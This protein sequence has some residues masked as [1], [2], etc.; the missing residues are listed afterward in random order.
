MSVG[1]PRW[2]NLLVLAVLR[3]PAHGLLDTRICELTY[4]LPRSGKVVTLPVQYVMNRGRILV[5]VAQADSKRWWRAFRRPTPVS[6]RLRG[7]VR[8]G[9]GR[10]LVPSSAGHQEALL[11]YRIARGTAVP[12]GTPIVVLDAFGTFGPAAEGQRH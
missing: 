12:T 3:S 1:P 9:V 6:I 5:A 7:R 11:A 10:V 2:V 4:V 8:Y